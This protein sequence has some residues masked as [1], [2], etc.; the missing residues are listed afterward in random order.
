MS[1]A[2]PAVPTLMSRLREETKE[3]H[4]R[5]ERK[6]I[7]GKL[8]SG[9][10]TRDEYAAWLGQMYLVH[11]ALEAA[12]ENARSLPG[13]SVLGVITPE[14]AHAARIAQDLKYFSVEPSSV[15]A[16]PAT[17]QLVNT[18]ANAGRTDAIATLG[19]TYVL[20][21]SM[22]GNSYLAKAVMRT[23]SLTPPEGLRYLDPYGPQQRER[24]QAWRAGVDA[25]TISEAQQ[26]VCV[27]AAQTMFDGIADL[28][29]ALG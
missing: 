3:H 6:P 11:V 1:T 29:E 16:L 10:V 21:G 14:Q 18:I 28:S 17:A 19:M 24:W 12:I 25:M 27:K 15:N 5:A 20:E 9:R 26:D 2:T 7:Q 8:V 23:L 13:G 4:T 22:N